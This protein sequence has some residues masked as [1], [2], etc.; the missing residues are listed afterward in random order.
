[1]K[2]KLTQKGNTTITLAK[3]TRDQLSY[4]KLKTHAKNLDEVIRELLK[5]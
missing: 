5:K 4:L 3:D 2:T 1:M